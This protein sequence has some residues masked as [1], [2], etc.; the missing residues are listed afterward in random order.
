M[1]GEKMQE[2]T[3]IYTAAIAHDQTLDLRISGE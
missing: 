1:S 3:G 2:N